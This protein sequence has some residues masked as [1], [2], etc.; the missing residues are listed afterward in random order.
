[1]LELGPGA[2]PNLARSL[3]ILAESVTP[4]LRIPCTVCVTCC[5]CEPRAVDPPQPSPRIH[6]RTHAHPIQSAE[7]WAVAVLPRAAKPHYAHDQHCGGKRPP[8][9]ALARRLHCTAAQTLL[10][11]A[12]AA[13]T[14]AYGVTVSRACRVLKWSFSCAVRATIVRI[15]AASLFMYT[16]AKPD[17][18]FILL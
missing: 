1:V 17:C 8:A 9:H 11:F 5:T 4:F 13:T 3:S 18:T 16:G 14:A 10:P 12:A 15:L 2:S 6:R 7:R